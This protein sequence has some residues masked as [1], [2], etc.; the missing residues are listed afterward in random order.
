MIRVAINGFGRIG[1]GFFK[2][3]YEHPDIDI[4]A[5]N[6]LADKETLLYL[7]KYDSAQGELPMH[8]EEVDGEVIINGES[9]LFL[10]EKDPAALPWG[11]LDIDVVVE[12]TGVFKKKEM[13]QKHID[14]GARRVVISA[15]TGED[16]PIGLCGIND[17]VIFGNNIT[18]NASCTT[19]AVAPVLA[20]LDEVFGV[21]KAMLSTVHG[22]TASQRLV[23]G[24]HK[25]DLRRGRAAAV[26]IVPTTTGAASAT[27]R[28]YT[29]LGGKF[30]GVSV[31]V[32]VVSGSI[33]DLVCIVSRNVT[34]EEVNRA[35]VEASNMPRWEGLLGAT[36]ELLVSSDIIGV[37]VASL[38]DLN[39]TRV[40]D[41]DMVRVMAW[42]DNEI[43][44]CESLL[45]HVLSTMQ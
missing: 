28:A 19:N 31:R 1:R 10:S 40:V 30:D 29:S 17:D 4:V 44:Y 21:K 32:P 36:N 37:R 27:T 38:V 8:I 9:V 43:G 3:A 25:K 7:L 6:D 15:P 11:D 35:L 16:I 42:Y 13:A 18:S 34:V 12:C 2:V 45:R 22:Y 5:I 26:N 24:P 23:D 14:A 41:G 20:V 33:V 39:M